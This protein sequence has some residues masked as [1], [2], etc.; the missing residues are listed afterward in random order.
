MNPDDYNID[1]LKI[2]LDVSLNTY[3][4]QLTYSELQ[5]LTLVSIPVRARIKGKSFFTSDADSFL[6]QDLLR[7]K[8]SSSGILPEYFVICK[9]EDAQKGI[10]LIEKEIRKY[11]DWIM[12]CYQVVDQ[13]AKQ[14]IQLIEKRVQDRAF[15]QLNPAKT[16]ALPKS[17]A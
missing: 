6:I 3:F 17:P 4:P 13:A 12:N 10:I 7:V 16:K 9:P 15:E 14:P 2:S 5:H 11:L 1:L 8:E